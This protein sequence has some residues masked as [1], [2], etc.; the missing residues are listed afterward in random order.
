MGHHS[1]QISRL[2]L[3]IGIKGIIVIIFTVGLN[4]FVDKY[5]LIEQKA[6][7]GNRGE[8][9]DHGVRFHNQAHGC[10]PFGR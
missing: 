2:F 10:Q 6:F 1:G 4:E 7:E 3:N 5:G 8:G 9:G